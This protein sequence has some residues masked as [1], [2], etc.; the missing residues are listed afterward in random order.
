MNISLASQPDSHDRLSRCVWKA[1][2]PEYTALDN[3]LISRLDGIGQEY[4][5]WLLQI[6]PHSLSESDVVNDSLKKWTNE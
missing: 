5:R 2:I 3:M 1:K 6:I 4:I